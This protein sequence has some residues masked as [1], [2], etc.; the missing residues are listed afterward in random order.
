MIS[1]E[2][3]II[4]TDKAQITAQTLRFRTMQTKMTNLRGIQGSLVLNETKQGDKGR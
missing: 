4:R 2:L 3:M 1:S